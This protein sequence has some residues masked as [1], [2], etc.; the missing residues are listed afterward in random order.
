MNHS[1]FMRDPTAELTNL[2]RDRRL[3]DKRLTDSVIGLLSISKE[4]SDEFLD[5]VERR[6]L[7]ESCN[8]IRFRKPTYT[9]PASDAILQDIIESCNVVVIGL[10]D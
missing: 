4:R 9:R 10:A 8:V 1:Y 3:P 5:S 7:D 6:L 2:L